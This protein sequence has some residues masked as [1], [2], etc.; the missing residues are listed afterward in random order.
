[1][2]SIIE[3]A[4]KPTTRARLMRVLRAAAVLGVS[5][6]FLSEVFGLSTPTFWQAGLGDWID[7]YFIN[8][9]LEHGYHAVTTFSDPFS[10]PMFYPAQKTLGYSHGLLCTPPSTCRYGCLSIHSRPTRSPCSSSSRRESF[11]ST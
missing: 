4:Q 11:A 7:P 8:Y 3:P 1:M 10:P 5:L 9:L 6:S 2:A